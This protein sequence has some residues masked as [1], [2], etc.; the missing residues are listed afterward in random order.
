MKV[1]N[2]YN[3]QLD[4][5]VAG[6]PDA[7][8]AIVFVHGLGTGKNE[9]YNLFGDIANA[10]A[11]DYLTMRF[12]VSGFGESEGQQKDFCLTKAADDLASV[13]T[14][15]EKLARPVNII[16]HSFGGYVT[17]HLNPQHVNKIIYTS[18]PRPETA[19]MVTSL[20]GRIRSK[21]DLDVNGVSIYHRSSG[22]IQEIGPDFWRDM[23][24]FDPLKALQDL[25]H[26]DRLTIFSAKGD[27]I[28]KRQS[29][30][31]YR[32]MGINYQEIAGDHDYQKPDDRA[33]L[34][35][36]LKATLA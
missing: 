17:S 2:P 14:E 7:K 24:N 4:V 8:Q 10:L 26:R 3:E 35:K 22:E 9:G 20:Q 32:E 27:D 31:L 33:E 30:N 28:V 36:R 19:S 1:V 21:G 25:T 18:T 23:N 11:N 13:L 15:A 34:I 5:L 6:N 29:G 12:D 16:A